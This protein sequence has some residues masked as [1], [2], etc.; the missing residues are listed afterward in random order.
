[1]RGRTGE[2]GVESDGC[3]G[4]TRGRNK[5]RGP[6]PAGPGHRRFALHHMPCHMS[7]GHP[8]TCF[9]FLSIVL[10]RRFRFIRTHDDRAPERD[11]G[12]DRRISGLARACLVLRCRQSISSSSS[13]L[14]NPAYLIQH[15]QAVRTSERVAYAL[16]A[17][18]AWSTPATFWDEIR[19][20][21]PMGRPP[22]SRHFKHGSTTACQ[23]RVILTPPESLS[24]S[25]VVR[26]VTGNRLPIN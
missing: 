2:S 9:H 10:G 20:S 11:A 17:C 8:P 25:L 7:H 22:L 23:S 16:G 26:T 1:M 3:S 21:W 24:L 12:G 4:R 15:T 13:S 18:A 19:L 14:T 5:K 6:H